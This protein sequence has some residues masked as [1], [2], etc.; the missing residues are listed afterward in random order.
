MAIRNIRKYGDELLRK[1]SR[2]VEKI[3]DRILTLLED[4]EETM[5]TAEGVGLAAPQV[6]ILKRVVVIDV[7][8]G[9]IKL[10]NPEII[11][12]E[13]KETDVEGCLSVPGK[14][15]EVERPYKVKVKAL[16]EKGEEIVLEGE[17]LLA[18]AFCHEIDHLDGVLFV[19]KVINK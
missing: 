5:Y 12:T 7:G 1:K 10:I 14:Q 9:I 16:N 2:K 19:D 4:M 18:R 6:G 13:G 8:E 3:D 11:E 15:G 17:G